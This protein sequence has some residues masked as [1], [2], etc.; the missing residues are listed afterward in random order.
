MAGGPDILRQSLSASEKTV[1]HIRSAF[2]LGCLVTAACS[3]APAAHSATGTAV[4]L[5]IPRLAPDG[6][7]RAADHEGA[8]GV[9][10]S[11]PPPKVGDRFHVDVHAKSTATVRGGASGSESQRS[12]YE[13]SYAVEVLALD[14]PAPSRVRLTF[15]KNVQRFQ[16][17]D[18]PTVIDGKA[19]V[20]D[21]VAP[22]VRDPTTGAAASEEERQRI[23]DV[24]P[25]LGTRT[26]IDQ[27]LPETTMAIGEPRKELASAVLRILHPRAWTLDKGNA[28]LARVVDKEAVFRVDIDAVSQTG[29][30][31][32]LTGDVHIRTRDARLVSMNLE[33]SYELAASNGTTGTAEIEDGL[34]S[35]QRK[36]TD[37]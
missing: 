13:S 34:I 16:G 19:Y 11:R 25:D 3:S 7:A 30:R 35:I 17:A 18:K 23:L 31:M 22:H 26:Q 14:G 20:L 15:D 4:R 6:G 33:G 21:V 10:F 2:A 8:A 5:E 12:S 1:R 32:S 37:L 27:V 24:F 36:V 28:V 9:R 29:L